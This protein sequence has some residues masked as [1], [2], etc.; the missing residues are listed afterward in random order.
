V[1][2][3]PPRMKV[4]IKF[5]RLF[6]RNY[7]S[8]PLIYATFS[9]IAP[10]SFF[11]VSRTVICQMLTI[12]IEQIDV[13]ADHPSG[14]IN[15]VLDISKIES[16]KFTPPDDDFVPEDMIRRALSVMNFRVKEKQIQLSV[17][18]G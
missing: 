2:A 7:R 12:G 8:A 17:R 15:D 4:R 9:V 5:T 13:A 3:E 14:V 6:R 16:G 1:V 11:C 18:L 10:V